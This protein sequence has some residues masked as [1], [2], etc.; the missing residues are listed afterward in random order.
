MGIRPEVCRDDPKAGE[1]D[2]YARPWRSAGPVLE[3]V[4]YPC[5]HGPLELAAKR[6][7]VRDQLLAPRRAAGRLKQL[8][9][10]TGQHAMLSFS[11]PT[12]GLGIVLVARQG[13]ARLVSLRPGNRTEAVRPAKFRIAV[14]LEDSGEDLNLGLG[15]LLSGLCERARLAGARQHPRRIEQPDKVHVD[16]PIGRAGKCGNLPIHPTLLSDLAR[17]TSTLPP[18]MSTWCPPVLGRSLDTRPE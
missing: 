18:T 8:D 14:L 12:D 17:L 3:K 15:D 11:D 9:P 6:G 4:G 13:H 16:L 2:Q 5:G 7:C 10:G 1:I